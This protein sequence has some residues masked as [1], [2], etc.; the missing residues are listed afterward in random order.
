MVKKNTAMVA[1]AKGLGQGQPWEEKS[2]REKSCHPAI[3]N[4]S[5]AA[6]NPVFPSRLT[7]PP[8]PTSSLVCFSTSEESDDDTGRRDEWFELLLSVVSRLAEQDSWRP[9]GITE[10]ARKWKMLKPL[11]HFGHLSSQTGA[12]ITK[13]GTKADGEGERWGHEGLEPINN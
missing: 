2:Q 13:S 8:S 6:S 9:R 11:R 12:F 7:S 5:S 10:A 3:I 1:V 4:N